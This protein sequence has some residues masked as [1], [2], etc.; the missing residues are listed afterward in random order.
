MPRLTIL[1][2]SE[3]E[4]E[5]KNQ[6]HLQELESLRQK[7]SIDKKSLEHNAKL[8]KQEAEVRNLVHFLAVYAWGV[9]VA[10]GSWNV[11]GK[12]FSG[13]FEWIC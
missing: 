3:Q 7:S 1:L 13:W 11:S 2:Y 12:N 10:V 6:E 4:M 9:M 8:K 5:K